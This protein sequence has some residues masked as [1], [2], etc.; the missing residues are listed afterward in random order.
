MRHVLG[1]CSPAL[2]R[3]AV[4]FKTVSD[5]STPPD[6]KCF[7][8]DHWS[9]RTAQR[10]SGVGSIKVTLSLVDRATGR[11]VPPD[12]KSGLSHTRRYW[13]RYG[14]NSFCDF[15]PVHPHGNE[16]VGDVSAFVRVRSPALHYLAF[17]AMRA[18]R[19]EIVGRSPLRLT[20][21]LFHSIFQ[22][23]RGLPAKLRDT[24]SSQN[25]RAG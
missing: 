15:R 24:T 4:S 25:L 2:G 17:P 14:H 19:M 5:V 23:G 21:G 22:S 9:N 11:P 16:S 1:R 13:S 7:T 8:L 18:P 10:I 20:G 12:I 3:R 6:R